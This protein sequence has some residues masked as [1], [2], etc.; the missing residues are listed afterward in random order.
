MLMGAAKIKMVK[1]EKPDLEPSFFSRHKGQGGRENTEKWPPLQTSRNVAT[2]WYLDFTSGHSHAKE[3]IPQIY[4]PR[5]QACLKSSVIY[6][7][8]SQYQV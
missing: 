6:K 4:P 5:V 2:S 7:G 8:F 3:I 1:R